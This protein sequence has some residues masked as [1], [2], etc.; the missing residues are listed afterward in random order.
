VL[1]I[2]VDEL[3]GFGEDLLDEGVKGRCGVWGLGGREGWV[4]GEGGWG[5]GF[6]TEERGLRR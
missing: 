1:E 5:E 2:C 3:G 4:G 6:E